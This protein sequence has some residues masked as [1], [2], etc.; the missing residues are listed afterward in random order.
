MLPTIIDYHTKEKKSR[1]FIKGG[2]K[3]GDYSN[4]KNNTNNERGI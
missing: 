2:D 3:Y 1:K 4:T